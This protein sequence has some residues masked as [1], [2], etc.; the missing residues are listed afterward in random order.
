[1]TPITLTTGRL[2]HRRR[3]AA[4]LSLG[5]LALWLALVVWF[6]LAGCAGPTS[7][8]GDRQP[9][10]APAIPEGSGN[11]APAELPRT[12]PALTRPESNEQKG[13]VRLGALPAAAQADAA[14]AHRSLILPQS[15][16][17]APDRERYPGYDDN[18]VHL[19]A[20]DPVSTFS[21][22][23]D[24]ASYSR[25]RRFLGLGQMPHPD[26]VRTEELI[27]YFD[28]GYAAPDDPAQPF[29]VHTELGPSP[30]HAERRL[31]KI[32]LKGFERDRTDLPPANLVFLV[33]V[34]GSMQGPDRLP[35]LKTALGL[36]VRQLR[37]EDRISIAV[38][39]GAAGV[40]L[41]PT[42][43]SEQAKVL[44][45]L[46]ALEAGGSTNGD[47]GIALAYRLARQAYRDGGI[48]RVI[49]AT[50]GD[51][52]VGTTD[53]AELERRIERERAGGI[54]LTV[55]GFGAGNYH[56][57]LMQTLAQKG[58]GQAAYIDSLSEA[59]K[60]L[61]DQVS[62]TLETI[63]RDVKIQVEFNP[64]RVAEYRLIGYETRHLER[65]DF[66]NDAV[67]AGDIG[68]GHTVTALYE[69]VPAGSKAR[70]VEPLRYQ[71]NGQGEAPAAAAAAASDEIAF[72]RLRYKRP[73]EA[74]SRL[75][76]RPVRARDG[77]EALAATSA[78][79]RF[80]AAVAGF[81]QLL[82]GG[83]YTGDLDFDAVARLARE[84]RGDDPQGYRSEFVTLADTAAVLGGGAAP[85]RDAPKAGQAS[86]R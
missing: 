43:G 57:A 26:A 59:R 16:W 79:F 23:V 12:D 11:P 22:D 8:E 36:L 74:A 55:L 1:M 52:N 40:V 6:A 3:A 31:L 72:V 65:E 27:N 53:L 41:E 21:I 42:P 44:A 50:D 76:E 28:Y 34:S 4:P 73:G 54:G 85:G 82:R 35:L 56:D 71:P 19:A 70:L 46:D 29:A 20:T 18:P 77:V 83:R 5:A 47:A 86:G 25:V 9:G 17:Q 68:A 84:A 49:L 64:A 61:V 39:A 24:T 30:W 78:D 33:D 38:Y 51:F 75:I 80:A 2:A 32:G 63:A 10:P 60:V 15:H 66:N 13:E 67:D 62:G 14:Y 48:N 7:D 81:G 37:A 69:I 58:D 45:A